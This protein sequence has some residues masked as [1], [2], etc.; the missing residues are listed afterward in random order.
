M[1]ISMGAKESFGKI[2]YPFMVKTTT[3]TTLNEVLRVGQMETS[4]IRKRI[5]MKNPDLTSNSR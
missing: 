3:I 2:K 1:V 4:L 5:S